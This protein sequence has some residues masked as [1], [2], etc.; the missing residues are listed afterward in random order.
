MLMT[1]TVAELLDAF[2]SPEPTPGGGSAAALAGALG[3][4][5]LAM[6]AGMRK[7]RTGA[8]ADRAALDDAHR[9]LLT[10][11]A[12]LIGLVE[13]D[14]AAYDLVVAAYRQPKATAEEQAARRVAIQEAMRVATEVPLETATVCHDALGHGTTIEA[15]GNPNARS[16]V[17]TAL[18]LLRASV[19]GALLN[20][21]VNLAN[22]TDPALVASIRRER[23]RLSP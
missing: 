19:Q 22:L 20:V 23:A 7:T 1:L 4:S 10:A 17:G 13:R 15:H 21:D 3:V 11:R 9:H 8:P 2:A 18:A 12:N 5:L 16:D 14:A 6:V